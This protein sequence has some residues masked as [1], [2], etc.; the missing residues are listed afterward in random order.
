[1][2]S[3]NAT[4]IRGESLLVKVRTVAQWDYAIA[5]RETQSRGS[6][7]VP[8]GAVLT[9]LQWQVC[10]ESS[11]FI[12][13]EPGGLGAAFDKFADFI[14]GKSLTDMEQLRDGLQVCA[15]F[16]YEDTVVATCDVLGRQDDSIVEVARGRRLKVDKLLGDT[17]HG[18]YFMTEDKCLFSCHL[19]SK[20]GTAPDLTECP[21]ASDSSKDD[22]KPVLTRDRLADKATES[23][24]KP[25]FAAGSLV[26]LRNPDKPPAGFPRNVNS[27][28]TWR[29]LECS[30]SV[31]DGCLPWIVRLSSAHIDPM[32]CFD[33]ADFVQ[34]TTANSQWGL[35]A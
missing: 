27:R 5:I 33:A 15:P 29:V 30:R 25:P 1:M 21:A 7:V 2:D 10:Q 19:F 3:N 24:E 11:Y 8:R 12:A 28:A 20:E 31:V 32:I 23:E 16:L 6:V 18:W 17:K 35:P 4:L 34:Y 13:A 26:L 9:V 22:S 14:F